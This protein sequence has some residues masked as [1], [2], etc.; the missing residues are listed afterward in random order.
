MSCSAVLVVR[1]A[2]RTHQV[3]QQI[4]PSSPLLVSACVC[5][6]LLFAVL[7]QHHRGRKEAPQGRCFC[8]LCVLPQVRLQV[9][10]KEVGVLSFQKK[11]VCFLLT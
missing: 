2:S 9:F 8:Q 3:S 1:C 4:C 10:S 7:L 6:L 5:A 11:S